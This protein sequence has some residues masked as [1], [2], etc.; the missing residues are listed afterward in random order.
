M[1]ILLLVSVRKPQWRAG[2]CWG[3]PAARRGWGI[4]RLLPVIWHLF[5]RSSFLLALICLPLPLLLLLVFLLHL[6]LNVRVEWCA[7]RHSATTRSEPE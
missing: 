6:L 3:W 1:R 7:L 2:S 4:C 5:T